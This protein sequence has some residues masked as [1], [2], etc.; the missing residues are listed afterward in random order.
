MRERAG[1]ARLSELAAGNF[2]AA[3]LPAQEVK[4][5]PAATSLLSGQ[6]AHDLQC[7]VDVFGGL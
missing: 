3:V 4:E 1:G 6:L 7:F 5:P 2:Q